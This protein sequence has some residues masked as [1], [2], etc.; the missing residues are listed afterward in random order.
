MKYSNQTSKVGHP[1]M[2]KSKLQKKTEGVLFFT[3]PGQNLE[4]A[5]VKKLKTTQ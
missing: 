2:V 1:K 4:E 3:K 5:F